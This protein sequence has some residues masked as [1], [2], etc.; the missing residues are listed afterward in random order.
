MKLKL[1]IS[2]LALGGAVL[3]QEQIRNQEQLEEKVVLYWA[4][5]V[6]GDYMAAYEMYPAYTRSAVSYIEWMMI[7]GFSEYQQDGLGLRLASVEIE[8]I[9]RP[10]DPNFSHMCEVFL[11]LRIESQD[12]TQE[13]GLV[14]NVWEMDDD[15]NWAPSMP[16]E[17]SQ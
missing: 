16:L 5:F 7:L 12:G 1:I 14:S 13:N 15:G 3:A 2:L 11:R 10:N 9:I 8:S 17:L 6:E 4:A